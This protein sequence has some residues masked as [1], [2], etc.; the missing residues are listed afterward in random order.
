MNIEK[1]EWLRKR[2][3]TNSI[4]TGLEE[5]LMVNRVKTIC[6]EALCP[7]LG[8]CF[9]RRVATFLIMGNTCTRNCA[10]CAVSHGKPQP[11][12]AEEPERIAFEVLNLELEYV[13]V[14]SVTRDDLTD[15]GAT[16]FVQV[17]NTIRK[18]CP[19]VEIEVL[20]PDF[21]GSKAALETLVDAAPEVLNHNI[22]TV[23]RLYPDVRPKAAYAR[24]L[25]LLFQAKEMNRSIITK[26]GFMVGLGE[27]E[28]EV[29]QLMHDLR[30]AGCD[31]LTIGQ[32][33]SPSSGH[34][35]VKKYVRPEV[36]EKYKKM[37]KT[38]GFQGVASSP[39]VRSSYRAREY[40]KKVKSFM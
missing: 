15:G 4:V 11:L 29:K 34:Y 35:P 6:Q 24:S 39:F 10:F 9:S 8:E 5:N 27:T 33:L 23:K 22:E 40:Y 18:K 30:L 20:I 3:P 14:T 1:P 19:G 12:D 21:M 7:N 13:V 37:A 16:H 17:T 36:F 31:I 38:E 28:D 26:S 2:L 25:K 32:Y